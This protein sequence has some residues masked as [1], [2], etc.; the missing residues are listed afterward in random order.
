MRPVLTLTPQTRG[1]SVP[2]IM[3]NLPNSGIQVSTSNVVP[4][5][6]S[7]WEPNRTVMVYWTLECTWECIGWSE[8]PQ[9][10]SELEITLRS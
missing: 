1:R 7:R 8:L 9:M 4:A 5:E 10:A 6:R 2:Q 3:S